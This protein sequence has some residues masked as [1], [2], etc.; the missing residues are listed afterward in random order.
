M[1]SIYIDKCPVCGSAKILTFE[2][3]VDYLT[4]N[5]TFALCKCRDCSFVFTQDF[6]AENEI[7]KYYVSENYT[8]HHN[9]KGLFG[10]AYNTVRSIMLGKKAALVKKFAK[11]GN[12]LDIGC[13][14]GYFLKK[15]QTEG[16]DI[17]G[18][19]KSE[20]VRASVKQQFAIEV[21]APETLGKHSKGS[22][23][24]VTMWHSLEHIEHL[25]ET[26]QEV[27]RVL[28]DD[29]TLIV[30]LP[31]VISYDQ[32]H[33][34]LYWAAYDV[35]R[36]LW[37]FSP[38]TFKILAKKQGF[39]VK[40]QKPMLFDAFY[41]SVLSERNKKSSERNRHLRC[42][43]CKGLLF[44]LWACLKTLAKPDKASSVMYVLKK[45]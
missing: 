6:P 23:D 14:Q 43:A 16:F 37:H 25:N 41:I 33:Y 27:H 24:V 35:P 42:P 21:E 10:F 17:S 7:G 4:D 5:G 44:G 22:F 29:G 9:A 30:A 18:I 28:K 36:H 38:K 31:N 15:M 1:N 2:Y 20:E 39:E 32:E 40:K 11:K 34:R 26:L 8:S 12:L 13:G 3:C 45:R 19:E